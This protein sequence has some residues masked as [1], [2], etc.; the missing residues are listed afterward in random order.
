MTLFEHFNLNDKDCQRLQRNF[1]YLKQKVDAAYN[2][3]F[4]ELHAN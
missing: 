4:K 2:K 1:K 3:K